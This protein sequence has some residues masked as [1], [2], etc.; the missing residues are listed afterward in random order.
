M[1]ESKQCVNE[2]HHA[3]DA[4][5]EANDECRVNPSKQELNDM[6]IDTGL[7]PENVSKNTAVSSDLPENINRN[8][9]SPPN[10]AI[11]VQHQS[12]KPSVFPK[13]VMR[14]F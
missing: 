8:N 14:E 13:K 5:S 9:S 3:K 12:S 1:Y 11:I 6:D 2:V 10:P 7:E 4:V